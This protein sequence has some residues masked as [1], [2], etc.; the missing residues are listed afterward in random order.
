[1]ICS[2][3]PQSI[4]TKQAE[5]VK[6]ATMMVVFFA[7]IIAIIIGSVMSS[8]I[9]RAI[10]KTN[11][12]LEKAA[13]GDLT[14]TINLKRKDE[15]LN[16]SN[17]IT[18]MI[19]SMKSLILKM[20][21]V[22]NTVTV[23]AQEISSNSELFLQAAKQISSAVTDI[24]L[25]LSQQAT[26]AER[27]LIQM[28]GLSNQIDT[29]TNNTRDMNSIACFTSQVVDSGIVII[30]ELNLKSKDTANITKSVIKDIEH[31]EVES[32][33]ISSIVE[34]INSIAEQ[35]NLLSLNASIEAARAGESGRG[36][37]VVADEIRKL[38][39]QSAASANQIGKI[40]DNIQTQTK[41][42][43]LTAKKAED[44]VVSQEI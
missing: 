32:M 42:T 36:F 6:T 20:N 43:V 16:L 8:S 1:M 15:F 28:E 40:I 7:S 3:I 21:G 26:D 23:S 19:N 9:S 5:G 30:D 29:L 17:C 13:D 12:T 37:S 18:M 27:C 14:A 35:T 44:I 34:T 10:E 41:K 39:E 25:G 4:I 22:S 11:R 2:L 31:L 24:D 38:A 33:S